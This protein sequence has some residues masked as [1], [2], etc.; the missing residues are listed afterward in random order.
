MT[1]DSKPG[2]MRLFKYS[3]SSVLLIFS[4]VLI[5]G[6]IFETQTRLSAQTHPA[7]A[8]VIMLVAIVWLT[9]VEGGQGALVGLGP[10]DAELYKESHPMSH[11]C[12]QLVYKGDNLNRYLL[13]RQFMVILIVF[14]VELCGATHGHDGEDVALWGL[15]NWIIGIFLSSGVA[16]ILFTCMVGQLNSEIIGCHYMLDYLNSWFALITIWVALAIEFSGILHICYIIQRTVARVAGQPIVSNEPDLNLF[17]NIFFYGRCLWSFALLCFAFAVT[18]TAIVQQKTTV[19]ASVPP[20]ASIV[21]FLVLMACI[22]ILEGAQIAY[23]AVVKMQKGEQGQDGNMGYFAKKS[24][25]ILFKN[26]N[27]NLAAFLV[28]RQLCVVSCMF[29][30]ARITAVKLEEGDANIFGVSDWVQ[31][32]FSTGLLGALIVAVVASVSWRLL[33]SAFPLAFFKAAP[34]Y[35]FL[36][37][38]LVLEMTGLLHGAWV[39]AD[40]I[41]KISRVKRDEVYI[42]TAE[43]RAEK[44]MKD[45]SSR[46]VAGDMVAACN[47]GDE[48]PPV[49]SFDDGVNLHMATK[50][51]LIAELARR[52]NAEAG[53]TTKEVPEGNDLELDESAQEAVQAVPV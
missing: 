49:Q 46:F 22:G 48:A 12:V 25:Q 34:A 51:E 23:F 19:W 17:Q 30:I 28:G 33:A 41:K 18:F 13:G 50:D 8:L 36:R 27:H 53:A 47:V 9:M 32:L 40:I 37:I 11:R 2:I 45:K 15:P 5:I 20:A 21:I 14:I 10:V 38:C 24:S 7:V 42:G 31:G 43:E 44:L 4:I 3:Y 35:V 16:M 6:N 39:I 26:D 52:D 1:A 29:F